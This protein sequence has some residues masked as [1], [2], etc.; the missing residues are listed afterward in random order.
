MPSGSAVG[1]APVWDFIP[2]MS[3]V[4]AAWPISTSSP[5]P[6]TV[7]EPN[8]CNVTLIMLTK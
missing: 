7:P 8:S 1:K 5:T 6:P 4:T 3:R 2:T